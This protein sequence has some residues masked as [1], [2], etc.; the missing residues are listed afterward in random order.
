MK[1]VIFILYLS[2]EKKK[3]TDKLTVEV[4]ERQNDIER[5][6]KTWNKDKNTW[7]TTKRHREKQK[8]IVTDKKS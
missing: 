7:R 5:Q 3:N 8:D 4:S 6:K 2:I 1:K